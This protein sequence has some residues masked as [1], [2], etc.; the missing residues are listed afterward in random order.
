MQRQGVAGE[1]LEGDVPRDPGIGAEV[2][3]DAVLDVGPDRGSRL[4]DRGPQHRAQ[5]H[6]GVVG[7]WLVQLDD[8]PPV[9]EEVPVE[10]VGD[11]PGEVRR[12]RRQAHLGLVQNRV[13][14]QESFPEPTVIVRRFL[15]ETAFKH[16]LPPLDMT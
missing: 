12:L 2:Q 3:D 16:S 10:G 11:L 15:G 7:Q 14:R 5:L 9:P 1:G 8:R 13:G 6:E 4:V